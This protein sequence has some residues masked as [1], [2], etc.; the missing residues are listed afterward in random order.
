MVIRGLALAFF[1][2]VRAGFARG[3]RA[4]APGRPTR[5]IARHA[6]WS[7]MTRAAG[8]R[9]LSAGDPPPGRRWIA[10]SAITAGPSS[11]PSRARWSSTALSSIVDVTRST[12]PRYLHHIPGRGRRG[13]AGGASHGASVRAAPP[14]RAARGA[15]PIS[16]G[17]W[18][19]SP[20]KCGTSPIPRGRPSSSP[21]STG[22]A[23]R[24]R[25]GG[26]AIPGHA[27]L[28]SDGRPQDWRTNR[29]TKIYDLSDPAQPRFV[30]TSGCRA[31]SPAPP[32]PRRKECTGP[33]PT[34]TA[35]TSPTAP[36]PPVRSRSWTATACSPAS[37]AS[38]TASRPR[39]RISYPQ[40][41]PARHVA[42]LGRVHTSY[43]ILGHAHRRLGGEQPR[44]VARHV[45]AAG[46]GSRCA[47]RCQEFRQLSLHGGCHR[48]DARPFSVSTFQVP[49]RPGDF[50]ARGGRF[51]PHSSHE[52]PSP[53]VYYG[54]LV[55]IAYFNAGV[56]AVDIR[57]PYRP[58][59]VATSLPPS[60][61][62]PPPRCV[63]V[64][65]A[66]AAR[67]RSRPT[68]SRWTTAASSTSPTARIPGLHIVEA[69]RRG[70][71]AGSRGCP[72][73]GA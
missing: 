32:A 28:V 10:L 69:H 18:A 17:R 38:R 9:G 53:P 25:T 63:K 64:D 4:I 23:R 43:P 41:R 24:T 60:P 73:R 65:G 15:R 37:R 45:R 42:R 48:R 22:S 56:R 34:R 35:S 8:A 57:D 54:R 27:Y 44:A 61:P 2:S 5:G 12:R 52:S 31:R 30:A 51:G 70:F 39:A 16:C 1:G 46:L 20:M 40:I 6:A 29:M 49:A 62:P 13:E 68:T 50:C 72:E 33:S 66:T 58:V 26:S 47:T 55:F 14:C 59:E 36:A 7:A 21:W 3:R 67:W 19:I 11:A 71:C